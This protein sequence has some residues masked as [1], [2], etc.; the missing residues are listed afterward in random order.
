MPVEMTNPTQRN[1]QQ[2][3]SRDMVRLIDP[4]TGAFLH[5]SGHGTTADITW[6]WLGF[7][8]RARTLAERATTRGEPWPFVPVHRS[9]FESSNGGMA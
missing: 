3:L 5:L 9:E 6:S 2:M 7:L 4:E 8:H 1:F